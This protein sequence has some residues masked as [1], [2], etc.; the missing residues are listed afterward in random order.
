MFTRYKFVAATILLLASDAALSQNSN[1]ASGQAAKSEQEVRNAESE[2]SFLMMKP[3]AGRLDKLLGDDFRQNNQFGI[4]IDKA[5]YVKSLLSGGLLFESHKT[6]EIT[7]RVYGDT[8]IVNGIET[9]SGNRNGQRRFSR[10]YVKQSGNWR[11]V[12][13]HITTIEANPVAR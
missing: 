5:Q 7:A 1:P 13:N 4:S 6:S 10:V 11:L 9:V 3:D 8:A 12:N 2:L